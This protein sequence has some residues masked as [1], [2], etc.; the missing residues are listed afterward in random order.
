MNITKIFAN[1]SIMFFIT[2]MMLGV[3][4]FCAYI[5]NVSLM[6]SEFFN[7]KNH[8]LIN[9]EQQEFFT[10]YQGTANIPY[11]SHVGWQ[12]KEFHGKYI[13][14][15]R[16]GWRVTRSQF[17]NNAARTIHFFG[18]STMWGYGV[19]DDGTIPS[20]FAKRTGLNSINYAELAWTNR[21][22]LNRLIS[23]LS[24][25]RKGDSVVFYDGYNDAVYGCYPGLVGAHAREP[26]INNALSATSYAS[27]GPHS[28]LFGI[29][30]FVRE[31]S[32]YALYER[33]KSSPAGQPVSHSECINHETAEAVGDF[34]VNNWRVAEQLVKSRGGNLYCVL[35]PSSFYTERLNPKTTVHDI[36]SVREVYPYLVKAGSSLGCFVDLSLLRIPQEYYFDA[37]AH[38]TREGNDI[39]ASILA[40]KIK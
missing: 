21:Q 40:E 10:E 7:Q 29:T 24:G 26:Q 36:E 18:G 22:S 35:Q 37:Q 30:A 16:N 39:V 11:K 25:I 38:L 34:V 6:R 15:S 12:S 33:I 28:L 4:E 17:E 1:A 20:L 19:K 27:D 9:Q 2:M 23:N 3:V 13:N 5:V 31:T 14:I 8:Q 32:S